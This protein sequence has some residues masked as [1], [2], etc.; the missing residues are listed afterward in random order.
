MHSHKRKHMKRKIE[1]KRER[2]ESAISLSLLC[3][4]Q[5]KLT[6]RTTTAKSRL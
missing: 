3:S 5:E 2:K 4:N 6:T 1:K